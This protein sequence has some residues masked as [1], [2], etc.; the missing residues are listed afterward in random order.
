MSKRF[1]RKYRKV[2]FTVALI[3]VLLVL[4][5]IFVSATEVEDETGGFGTALEEF[6]SILVSGI[7]KLGSGIGSGVNT[8]VSDLFLELDASGNIT[9]LS[10]F[11]GVAAI[12]GGVGLAIGLTTLIFNWVRSLGN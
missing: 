11:G 4:S 12:F 5:C 2:F 10:M 9:G 3:S 7:K 6:L 1:F 8:F